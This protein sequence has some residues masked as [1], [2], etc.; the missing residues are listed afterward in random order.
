MLK[1]FS[2]KLI[3][4]LAQRHYLA[5]KSRNI[6]TDKAVKEGAFLINFYLFI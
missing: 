4:A 3:A 2:L 1:V 5:I 6:Y